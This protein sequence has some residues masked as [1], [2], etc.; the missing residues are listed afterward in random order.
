MTVKELKSHLRAGEYAWPGGYPR[1]FITDDGEALG[2]DTVRENYRQVYRATRDSDATG[3]PCSGWAVIGVDINWE[4]E[5]LCDVHSGAS[6][7]SAY[8]DD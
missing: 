4:D 2:F 1:Y 3:R 5:N 7:P 8:A 6:I